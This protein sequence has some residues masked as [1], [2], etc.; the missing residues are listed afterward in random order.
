MLSVLKLKTMG[1]GVPPPGPPRTAPPPQQQPGFPAPHLTV[2]SV[3][4]QRGTSPLPDPLQQVILHQQQQHQ[5][6]QQQ[7]QQHQPQQQQRQEQQQQGQQQQRQQ[8][9]C[10]IQGMAYHALG[11]YVLKFLK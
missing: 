6:Q 5:Q 7:Q 3:A 2:S 1:G 11:L 10:H 8:Q 9:H 4:G